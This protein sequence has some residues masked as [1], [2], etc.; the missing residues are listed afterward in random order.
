M[1]QIDWLRNKIKLHIRDVNMTASE[2]DDLIDTLLTEIALETR[3]FKKL[4]GFT[5]HKD[6]EKYNFRY[7]ARMNEQI[8]EEPTKI[9]LLEPSTSDILN[10]IS[11][12]TFPTIPVEKELEI[13]KEQSQFL[14]LLDIF[15][16]YGGS[17]LD[18]FEERGSSYYF[19]YDE[20]WRELNDNKRFVF[21]AWV[22]PEVGELHD[23]ELSILLPTLIS[24][25]KF[26]VNDTLHSPDD[27]QASNYDYMRWFQNKKLLQDR[28]PTVAYST[29]RNL[30]WQY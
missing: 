4:Y 15:D 11:E 9:T 7:L 12:G 21:T 10:F 13:E 22:K 28:F 20:E 5:V 24:G 17:I 2:L 3:I 14:D 29:E 26:Y 27:V 19:C 25:A 1:A 8:E 18:K 16:E 6:I 30:Q 23:E